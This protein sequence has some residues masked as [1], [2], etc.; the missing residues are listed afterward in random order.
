MQSDNSHTKLFESTLILFCYNIPQ[1]YRAL[2]DCFRFRTSLLISGGVIPASKYTPS[3]LVG[4]RK[5]VN[6]LPYMIGLAQGAVGVY[7]RILTIH[8]YVLAFVSHMEFCKFTFI[9]VLCMCSL[10]LSVMTSVTTKYLVYTQYPPKSWCG[11]YFP[12]DH[13]ISAL[14]YSS[15]Q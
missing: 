11:G 7:T 5:Y 14:L 10:E 12:L 13:V 15:L 2:S 1:Q 6:A 3:T 4:F 8:T 9:F